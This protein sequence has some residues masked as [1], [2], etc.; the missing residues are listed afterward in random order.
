MDCEWAG[1]STVQLTYTLFG[2]PL[3]QEWAPPTRAYSPQAHRAGSHQI[4]PRVLPAFGYWNY[5]VDCRGMR[6]TILAF[7]A[8]AQQDLL[9][10][11]LCLVKLP[12]KLHLH[13][14]CQHDHGWGVDMLMLR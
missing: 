4:R 6:P 11:A 12:V 7:V 1:A 13:I 2:H 10:V 5:V 14:G 8:V 3:A 9:L